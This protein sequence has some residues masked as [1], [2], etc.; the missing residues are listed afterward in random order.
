VQKALDA[1]GIEYSLENTKD[2]VVF[3]MDLPEKPLREDF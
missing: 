3:W 1:M 2:G